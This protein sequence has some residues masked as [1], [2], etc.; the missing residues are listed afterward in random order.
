M[1]DRAVKIS[2][3]I[4]AYNAA[5]WIK[6]AVDS[7][8][9]QTL[10]VAEVIVIDDGSTDTTAAI[11]TEYGNRIHYIYQPNGGAASARNKGIT[12]AQG[13]WVAFLDADDEWLSPKLALQWAQ[14]ERHP[15]CI[16]AAGAFI[17]YRGDKPRKI[18]T[19]PVETQADDACVDA[20]ALLAAGGYIWTTTVLAQREVL[21]NLGGM[22]VTLRRSEDTD[23]WLRLAR[24]QRKLVYIES[25]IAKYHVLAGQNLTNMTIAERDLSLCQLVR[26]HMMEIDELSLDAQQ[27]LRIFFRRRLLGFAH[28]AILQGVPEIAQEALAQLE[29]FELGPVPQKLRRRLLMPAWIWE[30][31]W[32]CRSKLRHWLNG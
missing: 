14:I 20:Y 17:T 22:D 9:G 5:R 24:I 26:K 29:T 31:A 15:G 2:V 19:L 32:W 25:P 4:P 12:V 10:P 3:I 6:R 28:Q 27:Y 30:S 11:C 13:D 8:L 18:H 7:A 1:I 16:W 23:L 21:Q